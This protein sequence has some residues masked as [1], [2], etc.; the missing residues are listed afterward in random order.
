VSHTS[1]DSQ[2]G[3]FIYG[4][5]EGGGL[6][7]CLQRGNSVAVEQKFNTDLAKMPNLRLESLY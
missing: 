4:T 2:E 1:S 6:H 3:R 5:R 7:V